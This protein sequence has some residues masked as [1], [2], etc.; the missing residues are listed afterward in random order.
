MFLEGIHFLPWGWSWG[1]LKERIIITK[2]DFR[3]II[4]IR[5]KLEDEKYYEFL[6]WLYFEPMYIQLLSK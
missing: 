2:K 6:F 3:D 1:G 5:K 4:E